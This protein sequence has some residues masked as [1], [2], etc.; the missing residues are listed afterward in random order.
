MHSY[1]D[2]RATLAI[3]PQAPAALLSGMGLLTMPKSVPKVLSP[4][5]RNRYRVAKP[6]VT[7]STQSQLQV[8]RGH[9]AFWFPHQHR[10]KQE[11]QPTP[12][13]QATE[14]R[15]SGSGT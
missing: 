10:E 9:H 6:Q 2:Q 15:Y 13:E 5:C 7:L 4:L 11:M 8:S 3:A 14:S 12:G 1:G